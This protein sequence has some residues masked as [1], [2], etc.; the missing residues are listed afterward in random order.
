MENSIIIG[1]VILISIIIFLLRKNNQIEKMTETSNINEQIK[2]QINKIYKADVQS[3]R[4][5]KRYFINTR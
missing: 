5:L 1:L 2:E 3:I 4:N